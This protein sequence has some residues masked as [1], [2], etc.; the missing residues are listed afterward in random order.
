MT[1]VLVTGANRGIGL[2]FARQYAKDGAKVIACCRE[3][4]HADALK[5]RAQSNDNM[6][7]HG[8]DVSDF[9]AVKAL[10]K[11]LGREPLDILINTA[12]VYGPKSQ[13]ADDMDFDGWAHTLAVN[14]MGPLAVAQAFRPNLKR[15]HDTKLARITS[16]MASTA[17]T[18]GVYLAYRASKAA[19]NNVMKSLSV[20]WRG[21]GII[22]IVLDPGWVKTDMGGKN[23]PTS[24]DES[25]SGMRDVI[26]K[27]KPSDSG[28]FLNRRGEVEPW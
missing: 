1:T 21:D 9:A 12:G 2:E 10:A 24:P 18:E 14:T 27:L 22:C 5:K 23:A 28:K 20:D 16:G 6:D 4:A 8:L 19:L 15:G 11:D 25:V 7:V 26:A 3:P 13:S 17:E